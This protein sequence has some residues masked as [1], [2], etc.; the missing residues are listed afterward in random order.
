MDQEVLKNK[1]IIQTENVKIPHNRVGYFLS[2]KSIVYY[3]YMHNKKTSVVYLVLS[4]I[5]AFI[6]SIS[7]SMVHAATSVSGVWKT[8]TLPTVGNTQQTVLTNKASEAVTLSKA[9]TTYVDDEAAPSLTERNNLLNQRVN[10]VYDSKL[11][12]V[13]DKQVFSL[14]N[15]Y[16]AVQVKD[17]KKNLFVSTI[18]PKI[19]TTY[20][21][22]D[23]ESFKKNVTRGLSDGSLTSVQAGALSAKV[24]EIN[25]LGG[26]LRGKTEAEKKEIVEKYIS[27]LSQT[28][29][30]QKIPASTVKTLNIPL[31][32]N[33]LLTAGS[34][35]NKK[36]P[37]K[38]VVKKP[39]VKK[40][41]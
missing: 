40:K 13:N 29:I 17:L 32:K 34:V 25:A 9:Y 27:S 2:Y 33:I 18:L 23:Y 8:D 21:K 16:S 38:K 15:S 4:S 28:I 36:P 41:K 10:Y 3:G 22:K 26:L 7:V 6:I 30:E 20:F 12:L 39:V 19:S 37:V 14:L 1:E 31:V 11:L 5:V 24:Q 35:S